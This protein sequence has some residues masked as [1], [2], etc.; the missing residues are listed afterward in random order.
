MA[1]LP[2]SPR[3]ERK[4]SLASR[5]IY[6]PTLGYIVAFFPPPQEVLVTGQDDFSHLPQL[7]HPGQQARRYGGQQ[8]VN[9]PT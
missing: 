2:H 5:V 7:E 9:P 3:N 6:L 1:T 4:V 8:C